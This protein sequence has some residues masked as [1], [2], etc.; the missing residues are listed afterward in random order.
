M[1]IHIVLEHFSA[2][3]ILWKAP[4][5]K[6]PDQG[7]RDHT[8]TQDDTFQ[9]NTFELPNTA[10]KFI[11]FSI[12]FGKCYPVNA[13][14]HFL[15]QFN[16]TEEKSSPLVIIAHGRKFFF[17]TWKTASLRRHAWLYSGTTER[18]NRSNYTVA[19]TCVDRKPPLWRNCT[20]LC[21]LQTSS[22][23]RKH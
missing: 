6:W 9:F 19:I 17:G 2:S 14:V 18:H 22:S 4:H 3:F 13:E 1:S 21:K 7:R 15:D 10:Y 12:S 23:L 8:P 11:C 20:K 5:V 16:I